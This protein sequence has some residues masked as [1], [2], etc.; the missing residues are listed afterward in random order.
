[1]V[2]ISECFP[3]NHELVNTARESYRASLQLSRLFHAPIHETESTDNE[4]L[5]SCPT[6]TED[7]SLDFDAIPGETRNEIKSKLMIF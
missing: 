4:L 3:S 5:A 7:E 6:L 1:M 2:V